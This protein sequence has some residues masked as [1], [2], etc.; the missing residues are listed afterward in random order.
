MR[1][2]KIYKRAAAVMLS[3]AMLSAVAVSPAQAAVSEAQPS[4]K[5]LF[6][7]NIY[8]DPK[9]TET[10]GSFSSFMI[11]FK[12]NEQA[13]AT[14]WQ[15]CFAGLDISE[16]KQTYP[17]ASGGSFYGGFQSGSERKNT[18]FSFWDIINGSDESSVISTPTRVYPEGD[19]HSFGNEGNGHNY[20]MDY[21]WQ[22][23][24]WYTYLVHCWKDKSTGRTFIGQWVRDVETGKWDLTCYFD[25]TMKETCIKGPMS[26]FMENFGAQYSE[27]KRDIYMKNVYTCDKNTD[28]WISLNKG[29][30]SYSYFQDNKKG[31]HEINFNSECFFGSA[32]E[33]VENQ[34]EYDENSQRVIPYSIT[35]PD[36][37]GFG[38]FAVNRMQ[39]KNNT[40]EWTLN[41]QS[42]PM[43][44][45]DIDVIDEKD[46]S[47]KSYTSTR[48]EKKTVALG[49]L[50]NGKYMLQ[51]KFRDVFDRVCQY[52][53]E[54]DVKDGNAHCEPL[55]K[56]LGDFNKDKSVTL[57]DVVR[58][59]KSNVGL[60]T[61]T[62]YENML[63]DINGDGKVS[64]KDA[65]LL[66]RFLLHENLDYEIGEPISL[67]SAEEP[68]YLPE[69]N[70]TPIQPSVCTI[71]FTDNKNWGNVYVYAWNSETGETNAQWPGAVMSYQSTNS[72]GQ[73]VYKAELN[74][75][76]D[77]VIFT[78]ASG[79]PQTQDIVWDYTANGY[80]ITEQKAKNS[81]GVE[82]C[83]ADKW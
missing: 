31:S 72:Y 17:N 52:N 66:Q 73:T 49:S 48:P 33:P 37:P 18:L 15:M 44:S 6:A 57:K 68:Q 27:L 46:M 5:T 42:S 77:M 11:D 75:K 36:M 58:I 59:L 76:F 50:A 53:Y 80:W 4:G 2:K 78:T 82:V 54:F 51:A 79:S 10:S 32:G 81:M 23:S 3:A 20:A 38:S 28:Q 74:T 63:G 39:I 69:K 22:P 41:E 19:E 13:H 34:E 7:H 25:T 16:I 83:I 55:S 60:V 67:P 9:L 21:N 26:Q 70:E 45:F 1:F 14:Y 64:V 30:M 47:V 56:L 71:K 35:Q 29:T 40:L 24:K 12:T 62:P 61:A 43:L 8:S 65:V